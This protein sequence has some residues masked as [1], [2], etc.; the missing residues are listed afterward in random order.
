MLVIPALFASST[1]S[2]VTQRDLQQR[3]FD[4]PSQG[5]TLAAYFREVSGDRFT[6]RGTV[7]PWVHT[8]VELVDVALGGEGT[9]GAST[10][11]D[12][13]IQAIRAVDANINF[14]AYDNDGPDGRPNSG[15]DDGIVDGGVVVITAEIGR[16]CGP[17]GGIWPHFSPLTVPGASDG[18]FRVA[19]QTPTGGRIAVKAYVILPAATCSGSTLT[20]IGIAAHELMH[21]LFQAPEMYSIGGASSPAPG[22]GRLWRIGCW[23]VM[24]AGSAWGCG[25]SLGFP[26]SF[27]PVHPDPWVKELVGWVA[28]DTIGIVTDTLLT[29]HPAA[30][31]GHTVRA[32]IKPGEYWEI[33]YRQRL[34]FDANVPASGVLIY[35]VVLQ[36]APT[37]ASCQAWCDQPPLLVEADNNNGLLRSLSEGGNKGEAGDAFGILGHTSF[38]ATTTP[39]AI[40]NDGTPTTLNIS[41]IEIDEAGRV[42]RVRLS[43]G[44]PRR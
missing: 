11:D 15:D 8:Q 6:L 39:A 29:L 4:G 17:Q 40:A 42:A 10:E 7:T 23:D 9:E 12:Y 38:S 31:G 30:L 13:V 18:L 25:S 37:P 1:A 2:A 5:G 26:E 20:G 44:T 14:G 19:D 35:H 21:L 33:E 34:G 36:R 43:N 24:S 28:A 22:D 27:T 16:H 32:L 41:S 3:F